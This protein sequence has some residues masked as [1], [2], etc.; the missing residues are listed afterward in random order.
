MALMLVGCRK[1][2]VLT[3]DVKSVTAPRQGLVDTVRLHSDVCDFELVSAPAWTGAAL[4]DSVLSLQIK[5]NETAGPRSG[6]VIVRNGELTLSIPIEQRGATTYLTITEPADGT[7]TIPQSGGEVKITVETDGGDVRLEGVEGVT[8]KY[9]DGEV[10]LTGKGNTGKTRK[11]KGSLV[12][13]EVSTPITVVEKGAICA[14]CGGK[15]QV[16]CRICGG[17]G[18]DYCPYRPCDLC[19]GRGRTRCPECGGKGK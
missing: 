6:N 16:T 17:E 18:V 4:A 7:V 8:A 12:A 9:A 14:R 5:A 10:T 1:A 2:S 11:T 19:H 15:G 3:A 13:D